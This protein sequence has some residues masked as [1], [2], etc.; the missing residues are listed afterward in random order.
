MSPHTQREK[1][2]LENHKAELMEQ[3]DLAERETD[4]TNAKL[5]QLTAD[6]NE[7]RQTA[8]QKYAA[9]EVSCDQAA[10]ACNG[11]PLCC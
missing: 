11:R 10:D 9:L 2:V 6:Y 4:Q 7:L 5:Q 8:E 3:K 1:K